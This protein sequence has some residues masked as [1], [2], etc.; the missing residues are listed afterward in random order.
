MV[1]DTDYLHN[2]QI[3]VMGEK[4]EHRCTGGLNERASRLDL[5]AKEDVP[6]VCGE[7]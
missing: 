5:N 2:S 4:Q 7:P 3:M 6:E 1:F